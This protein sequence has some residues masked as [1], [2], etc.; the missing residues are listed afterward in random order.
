[1]FLVISPDS[2]FNG[3]FTG[4]KFKNGN[5]IT[6]LDENLCLWFKM[7]GFKVKKYE[8]P[9]KKNEKPVNENENAEEINDK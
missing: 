8:K 6:E 2:S 3:E 9:L 4:Y 1:M 5:C 7:L